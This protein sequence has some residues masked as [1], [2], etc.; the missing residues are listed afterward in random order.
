MNRL[1]KLIDANSPEA[2]ERSLDV[3]RG[4]GVIVYPTETLYGIGAMATLEE[5][6]K[7]VFKC[8][9]RSLRQ[10]IPVLVRDVEMMAQYVE[11]NSQAER[12]VERFM[13]GPLT[14]V[15]PSRGRLPAPISA[16]TGTIAVRI[17]AHPF[18]RTL[19]EGLDVPLTSTSANVSG[20]ENLFTVEQLFERFKDKVDLVVDAG[21][22]PRSRGSTIINMAVTPP[23]LIRDGDIPFSTI[24]E[25]MGW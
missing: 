2:I 8:K 5:A 21:N 9:S 12:L 7:R 23:R 25:F 3:L 11:L 19:F 1:A 10:P 14:L 22:I 15:L 20:G 18:V 13:P 24:E 16:G 4:G 6:V 17:S